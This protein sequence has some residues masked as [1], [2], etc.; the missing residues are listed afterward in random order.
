MLITQ[1]I[2]GIQTAQQIG[3]QSSRGV[4]LA[5]V[6]RPTRSFSI[7]ADLAVT[8]A[9]FEEFTEIVGGVQTDRSGNTPPNVPTRIWNISPTQQIGQFDVTGTLRQVGWRWG[10]NANS[11]NRLVKP[12]T[13]IEAALAYRL[14]PGT[15]IAVRGRNLT[16]RLYTQS[17]SNTSGRLEPGRSIDVTFT[18]DLRDF[19]R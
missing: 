17:V 13:T 1:L 10:D 8:R 18:T 15:R 12:Y 14:R 11:P 4:E 5:A 2:N 9:T 7:A 3:A 16:D 6:A 19:G